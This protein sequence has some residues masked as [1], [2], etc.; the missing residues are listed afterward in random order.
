VAYDASSR[1]ATQPTVTSTAADGTP[2]T[3]SAPRVVPAPESHDRTYDVRASDRLDLLGH[4]V[5]GDTTKW[6]R[7]ADAN[8]WPDATR[9]ER[10]GQRIDLPDA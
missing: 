1:Y 9:L 4:A 7:I 5:T 8:P 10:P 3:M 2:V 6:W